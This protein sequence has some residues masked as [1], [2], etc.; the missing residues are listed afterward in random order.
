MLRKLVLIL[1]LGNLLLWAWAHGVLRPLGLAPAPVGEPQRLQQQLH[2]GSL[3][4]L[5]PAGRPLEPAAAASTPVPAA[6][7]AS[8]PD[9]GASA[10]GTAASGA[11]AAGTAAA[12][13]APASQAAMA[14]VCLRIGP[15]DG[16]PDAALGAALQAA[17][18]EARALE[19]DLPA[20]WMVLMGPYAD[21]ATL[22]RKSDELRRLSL[23]GDSFVPVSARPRYMPGISLG[24]FDKREQAQAQ[25]RQLQAHGVQTA[26]V[27]QR[28][29]GMRARYWV[30]PALSA[31]QAQ[32]LR[33]LPALL[34]AKRRAQDCP[35]P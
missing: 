21:S 27:V 7:G 25:L 9:A 15:Y 13:V 4:L 34:A 22:Q 31:S 1:M 33:T 10:P 30:L 3:V 14:A 35:G 6:S 8:A 23:P 18:L 29:L 17:G 24:V 20:Q 28:N 32:R 26:H 12:P 19:Q 5:D 2:P 11:A 16:A